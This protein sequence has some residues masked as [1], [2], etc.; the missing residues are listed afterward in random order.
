MAESGVIL[1]RQ[2]RYA[3]GCHNVEVSMNNQ[4]VRQIHSKQMNKGNHCIRNL[5]L[6]RDMAVY[7]SGA[8]LIISLIMLLLLTI[9][10]V[11]AIQTTLLEEKMAG[12]MREQNIAF[13]AAESALRSGETDTATIAP[14][15]F[16]TGSTK[17]MTGI[18]WANASVRAYNANALYIIE[19]PTITYGFGYEAGMSASSAQTNYWYRITAR[20][21]SDT[22]N[23]TVIL[24]SIFIR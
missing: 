22:A 12:N 21:K 19:P 8:V 10:G 1:H 9:I 7:Q 13:Q 15:D 23:A 4:L 17:P 16:Y 18:N 14:S 11:T 2:L 24:Q 20:G 6:F 5:A 3:I